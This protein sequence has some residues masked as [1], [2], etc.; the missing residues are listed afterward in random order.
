MV[1][2]S[3]NNA[4][5]NQNI[6]IGMFAQKSNSTDKMSPCGEKKKHQKMA[7]ADVPRKEFVI[8]KFS[9]P[10]QQDMMVA[11]L[12]KV[13]ETKYIKF[14]FLLNHYIYNALN[15]QMWSDD[16]N[17]SVDVDFSAYKGVMSSPLLSP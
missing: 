3:Q 13:Y 11:R 12:H 5:S 4:V 15:E 1:S 10:M 14:F 17:A 6:L 2:F 16:V 7:A 8:K 9:D